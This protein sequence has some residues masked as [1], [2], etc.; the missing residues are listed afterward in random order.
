MPDP[1]IR[2]DVVCAIGV[3]CAAWR[4]D[5]LKLI[6]EIATHWPG[7]TASEIDAAMSAGARFM[8]GEEE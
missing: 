4:F 3:F 1:S 7:A 6:Q 8:E 5:T 2:P